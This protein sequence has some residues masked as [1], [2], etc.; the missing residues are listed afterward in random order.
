MVSVTVPAGYA[1]PQPSGAIDPV[2]N[3]YTLSAS[4]TASVSYVFD[5]VLSLDHEQV[6][7][8]TRHPVQ[9]SASITSHAYIEPAQLVLYVLMSDVAAQY[10]DANQTTP[11][12]VA[13]FTGRPSKSVAAYQQMLS[14]QTARI[15][16][17]VTTRLRTYSNMLITRISPHEDHKSITGARFR[18]EFE[19]IF[20]AS[21]Q[22]TPASSRPNDTEDTGL[23]A[24]NTQTP[25]TS[26]DQQFQVHAYGPGPDG[27]SPAVP[28][29]PDLHNGSIPVV[30]NG[31]PGYL[32]AP[33]T[34]AP[35]V[36]IFT[37]QYA[38]SVS[39]IDVPGAGDFSSVNTTALKQIPALHIPG[40]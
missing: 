3:T 5:A 4:T 28:L 32:A 19:Q 15:P 14:L 37:P 30:D 6:L 31:V 26:V 13:Q 18:I 7:T 27:P 35:G 9:T 17:I 10:V 40:L 20:V 21:T 2:T 1:S 29:P 12:Y 33:G 23:G 39:K 34:T 16:L 36:D 38:T 11:P 25:P 24:V 8:K 22:V